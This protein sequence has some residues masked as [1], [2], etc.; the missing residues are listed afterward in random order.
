MTLRTA[1]RLP[2]P[3][4][5]E[6]D[7]LPEFVA[8]ARGETSDPGLQDVYSAYEEALEAYGDQYPR[9]AWQRGGPRFSVACNDRM[10]I[11]E[12]D[13][14]DPIT[15]AIAKHVRPLGLRTSYSRVE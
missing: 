9:Q 7:A 5:L 13:V 15:A 14:S 1:C 10:E 8:V 4:T 3:Y 12:R 2:S 11:V 6:I